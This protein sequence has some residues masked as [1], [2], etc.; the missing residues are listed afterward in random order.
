MSLPHVICV[1]CRLIKPKSLWRPSQGGHTNIHL[2]ADDK[3][4]RTDPRTIDDKTPVLGANKKNLKVVYVL[5][6]SE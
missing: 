6:H 4:D 1:C 5:H 2:L 3:S